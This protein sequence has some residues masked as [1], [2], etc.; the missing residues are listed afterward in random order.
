M[1]YRQ[2][3]ERLERL[4]EATFHEE[5]TTVYMA[6]YWSGARNAFLDLANYYRQLA[7]KEN[8]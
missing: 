5:P 1:N 7:E 2:E 3:A 4:A 8:D 6:G